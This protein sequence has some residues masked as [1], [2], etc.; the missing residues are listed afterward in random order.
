MQPIGSAVAENDFFGG[1][2]DQPAERLLQFLRDAAEALGRE[3]PGGAFPGDGFLSRDGGDS[4]QRPLMRAV[5]PELAL[6]WAEILRVI[7]DHPFPLSRPRSLTSQRD[8]WINFRRAARR[9]VT[10]RQRHGD[11][12]RRPARA[13]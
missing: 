6:E 7:T 12:R 5:E 4:R 13:P 3:K 1:S 9:N 11:E 8:Q 2:V 10:G